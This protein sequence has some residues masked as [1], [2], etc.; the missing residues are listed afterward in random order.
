[1]FILCGCLADLIT[2]SILIQC[3]INLFALSSWK[4][5]L[6]FPNPPSDLHPTLMKKKEKKKPSKKRELKT[7]CTEN[8]E[9]NSVIRDLPRV[10][11]PQGG[12][13]VIHIAKAWVLF[14]AHSVL[15]VL[16]SDQNHALGQLEGQ[17]CVV[18]VSV[19]VNGVCPVMDGGPN[20]GV[21]LPLTQWPLG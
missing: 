7:H 11:V 13:L 18:G 1:M 17:H 8:C 4:S 12:A 10:F 14:W 20:Q 5:N 21:F 19:W 6:I 2:G 16:P 9:H 3:V 15:P